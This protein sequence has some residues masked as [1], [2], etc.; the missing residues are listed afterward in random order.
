MPLSAPGTRKLLTKRTIVCE[1]F[2]RED[3]LLDVEGRLQDINEYPIENPWR[4]FLA[5]GQPAHEMH[6]RLCIDDK[7]VIRA[8]EAHIE[9]APYPFCQAVKPNLERLIGLRITEG[10]KQRARKLIGHTEGCTHV[11][12]LIEALATVTIRA[13]A[14]KVRRNGSAVLAAFGARDPN[15]PP[16]IDTCYS[17]ARSSPVVKW[18]YPEHYHPQDA[19]NEGESTDTGESIP[20]LPRS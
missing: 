6:V 20:E 12:T 15:R 1:G 2:E 8:V 19:H 17:H 9:A 3:G 16:L 14:G 13:L 5:P 7:L 18:L 4:A 10:F 11:L